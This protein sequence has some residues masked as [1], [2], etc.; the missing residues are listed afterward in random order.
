MSRT[1]RKFCIA[2]FCLYVFCLLQSAFFQFSIEEI[3]QAFVHWSPKA[4]YHQLKDSNLLPFLGA[5]YQRVYLYGCILA[6]FPLGLCMPILF[7]R[8]PNAFKI[9]L[10]AFFLSLIT[11]ALPFLAGLAP[12]DV[13]VILF[14]MLGAWLGYGGFAL[15]R[16]YWP[17]VQFL[18][19]KQPPS[20][21]DEEDSWQ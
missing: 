13:N 11:E 15:W 1:T 9:L 20:E 16:R 14:S 2:A 10:W 7:F 12:F 3:I 6:F 18:F 21:D 8:R 19:S 5:A 17:Q 4:V